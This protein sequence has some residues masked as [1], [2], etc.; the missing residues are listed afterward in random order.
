MYYNVPEGFGLRKEA[1]AWARLFQQAIKRF[2]RLT[3]RQ[4][5]GLTNQRYAHKTVGALKNMYGNRASTAV[6]DANKAL[7]N[8]DK[9]ALQGANNRYIFNQ[10]SIGEVQRMQDQLMRNNEL[11]FGKM[12]GYG[13]YGDRPLIDS[14]FK[15]VNPHDVPDAVIK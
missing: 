1:N 5:T 4:A 14:V 10:D 11:R 12:R 13:S 7:I 8:G 3:L 15:H 9:K 2:P 6:R